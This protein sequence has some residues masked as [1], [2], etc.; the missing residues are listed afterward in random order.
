MKKAYINPN[1]EILL[2]ETQ[3]LLTESWGEGKKDGSEAVS[4]RGRGRNKWDDEELEE[5][6]Y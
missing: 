5:E 1:V 2:V 4:R 3:P 6:D